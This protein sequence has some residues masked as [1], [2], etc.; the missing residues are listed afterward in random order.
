MVNANNARLALYFLL[1]GLFASYVVL[2][3]IFIL[4]WVCYVPLFLLFKHYSSSRTS[5]KNYLGFSLGVSLVMLSWMFGASE[6]YSGYAFW[7]GTLVLCIS[8]LI[9]VLYWSGLFILLRKTE[10][11]VRNVF[12]KAVVVSSCFVFGEWLL[13]KV[14]DQMPYYLYNSG[15]GLLDNL[16]SLQWGAVFGLPILGFVVVLI[17]YLLS[18]TLWR[19]QWKQLFFLVLGLG[20]FMIGGFFIYKNAQ[21]KSVIQKEL[22]IAIAAENIPVNLKWDQSGGNALAN[23]LFN[24]NKQAAE[25]SPD[26]VLWSETTVPWTFKPDDDLLQ[27]LL[28]TKFS[29][30]ATHLIGYNTLVS[31]SAVYN[32][33]YGISVSSAKILGR[34]DKRFLL[35]F[36]ERKKVGLK[37]PFSDIGSYEVKN[38]YSSQPIRTPVA[39]VGVVV[40]NEIV[41]P[42]SASTLVNNGAECL[43]NMSN[44]GWFNNGFLI[45]ILKVHFLYARLSAVITRKDVVINSNN[46]FSG[47]VTSTGEIL[48]KRKSTQPFVEIV[49]LSVY[50]SNPL[51]LFFPNL[52]PIFCAFA[53]G[54]S[55]FSTNMANKL[56]V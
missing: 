10:S 41:M 2:N 48:L 49:K 27:E 3:A 21:K 53:L 50:K 45:D 15:Y 52:W 46:G 25:L 14:F 55:L 12:L 32:S 4:S 44:D 5:Y 1:A 11:A 34:Y 35:D 38:G 47:A 22:S 40:C 42:K 31:S 54:I 28:K 13:S 24:L 17:N 8:F 39:D 43:V 20:C 29:T 30:N 51:H 7:Y 16:Y 23:R 26:I 6:Q 18:D 36:V 19:K 9:S 56:R 37:I 33:V